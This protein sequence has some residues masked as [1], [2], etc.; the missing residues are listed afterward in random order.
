VA[1]EAWRQV[2]EACGLALTVLPS[3]CCGMAG[4]FGHEAEHRALSEHIYALSWAKHVKAAG[5]SGRLLVDGFSCRSQA[6][7]VDR[8][9]PAHP[10]Q[11]L[12]AELAHRPAEAANQ[13]SRTAELS[14]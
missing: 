4:T 11:A 13:D 10:V 12:L 6:E 5:S 3:G 8:V 7:I 14:R 9:R 2:F 1:V